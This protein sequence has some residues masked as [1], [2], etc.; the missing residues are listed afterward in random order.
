MIGRASIFS[1]L[2]P[3]AAPAFSA[4]SQWDGSAGVPQSSPNRFAASFFLIWRGAWGMIVDRE[5]IPS[6]TAYF[7]C[8][9]SSAMVSRRKDPSTRSLYSG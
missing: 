5:E 9:Q 4:S 3:A 6:S 7:S 8:A 1:R 2:Y